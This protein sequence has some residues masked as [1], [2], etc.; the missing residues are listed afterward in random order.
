M[1]FEKICQRLY[2][3]LLDKNNGDEEKTKE[4][5]LIF[6]KTI[7]MAPDRFINEM[8]FFYGRL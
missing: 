3:M 8:M 1:L 7:G 5:F 6:A 4:D 2:D